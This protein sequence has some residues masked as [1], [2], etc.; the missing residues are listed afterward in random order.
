[1]KLREGLS[2]WI[3]QIQVGGF[4]RFK[5]VDFRRGSDGINGGVESSKIFQDEFI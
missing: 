4:F 3:F 1:M 2:W 5:L